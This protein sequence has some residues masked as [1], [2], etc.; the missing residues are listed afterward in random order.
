MARYSFHRGGLL[1]GESMSFEEDDLTV[2]SRDILD[3]GLPRSLEAHMVIK[4][5]P[6][7]GNHLLQKC[8]VFGHL[9]A[10]YWSKNESE[11][12]VSHGAAI[13]EW[14]SLGSGICRWHGTAFR[15][16]V[17][18]DES[19]I[20]DICYNYYQSSMLLTFFPDRQVMFYN[21]EHI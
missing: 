7:D 5:E 12:A 13:S 20:L 14:I 21:Y 8:S 16:L 4:K 10:I 3:L 9:R 6:P 11:M 17:G 1:E 2:N 15:G 18:K 19:N